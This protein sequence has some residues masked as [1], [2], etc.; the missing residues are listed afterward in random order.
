MFQPLYQAI[1]RR[2]T[3]ESPVIVAIDGR[4]G[5]GKSQLG[6]QL[7]GHFHGALVHMD[8]FFLR[9]EQRTPQRL[10]QPG[11]NVDR[12]RFL[13]DVLLPLSHG[14]DAVYQPWDCHTGS[15][16]PAQSVCARPVVIVEGSYSMHPQLRP[17]YHI[18]VFLTTSPEEQRRRLQQRNP[19]AYHRFL[20]EWIPLEE[21][22]F[23][24]CQVPQAC[25]FVL[26][27]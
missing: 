25:D 26:E 2:L 13:S 17:F 27:T 12:E 8:D 15:F 11:G 7:Q 5:A 1:A 23:S 19:A 4:C 24:Q 20:T 16:A 22:Y 10:A 14:K 9:P 6:I 18:T 21:A 3:D